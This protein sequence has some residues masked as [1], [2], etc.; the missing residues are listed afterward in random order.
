M[1][2]DACGRFEVASPSQL[3]SQAP[4]P[5]GEAETAVD[6]ASQPQFAFEP[7]S[8]ALHTPEKS[9][10]FTA[11]HSVSEGGGR[12]RRREKGAVLSVYIKKRLTPQ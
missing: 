7:F 11:R 9:A 10:A 8:A 12:H 6:S 5:F 3:Y 2:R 4:V 1:Q